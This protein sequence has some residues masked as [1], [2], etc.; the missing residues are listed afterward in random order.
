[1]IEYIDINDFNLDYPIDGKAKYVKP[2]KRILVYQQNKEV[3]KRFKIS[4]AIYFTIHGLLIKH[5]LEDHLDNILYIFNEAIINLSIFKQRIERFKAKEAY[6]SYTDIDEL[7]HYLAIYKNENAELLEITI[8]SNI[9]GKR[10][11]ITIKSKNIINNILDLI[12]K[13]LGEESF[14]DIEYF[15]NKRNISDSFDTKKYYDFMVFTMCNYFYNYFK[16]N[17]KTLKKYTLYFY[18]GQ[19]FVVLNLLDSEKKFNQKNYKRYNYISYY[20]Y[21]TDNINNCIERLP[22]FYKEDKPTKLK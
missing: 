20:K 7:N 16:K 14:E 15:E 4:S 2:D 22:N 8:K 1:M 9:K 21:L 18:V 12:T 10:H 11:D 6:N 3:P 13:D 19:I 17:C 5:K